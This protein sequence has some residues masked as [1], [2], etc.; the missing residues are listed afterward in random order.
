[1]RIG[2]IGGTGPAGTGLAARLAAA[3]ATVSIGSRDPARGEEVARRVRDSWKELNLNLRGGGNE[4]AAEMDVVVIATPPEVAVSTTKPL[5]DL[6]AGKV[7]VSMANAIWR[8]GKEFLAILPPRGSVAASLQAALPRS[9]LS[10][11]FHHLPAESLA[12]LDLALDADVM[13]FSDHSNAK[14]TTMELVRSIPGL[15]AFDVG[16]MAAATAVESLTAIL[17]TVSVKY[18]G[19]A[20]LRL[21][22]VLPRAERL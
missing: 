18:K 16:S 21:T 3:G 7:V 12:R 13:V 17:V 15:R 19:H 9:L 5:A 6:L 10:G 2:I 11:A 20:S 22:G 8:D 14:E 4:S 1:M